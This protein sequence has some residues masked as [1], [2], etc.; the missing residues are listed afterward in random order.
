MEYTV[1][2]V[3]GSVDLNGIPEGTVWDIA[4][5]APMLDTVSG[6]EPQLSTCFRIIYDDEYL[7]VGYIVEDNAIL[8]SYTDHDY[9]LYKEDV[10][11][12]FLSPTGSL[13]CYYE[14]N[15]SPKE[16]VADALVLNNAGKSG[17]SRGEL[18]MPL[19]AWDCEGL[20][21][22][23]DRK[24]DNNW[25]LTV[26]IPFSMLHLA[27]NRTPEPGEKWKGNLFRIEYGGAEIEYSAWIPTGLEDFHVT[28]KFGTLI[29]E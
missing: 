22:K 27:E 2:K 29:F 19:L 26:A 4:E 28:G 16:V 7:Y 18:F 6:E 14:F 8:A 23:A 13:H 21:I 1:N 12:I 24:K 3:S 20:R 17:T 25:S 15:F 10:V 9:P 5:Q 11:E